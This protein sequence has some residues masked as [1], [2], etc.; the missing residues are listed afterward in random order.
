V[1][2]H[3]GPIHLL[4][5][6]VQF[7]LLIHLVQFHLVHFLPKKTPQLPTAQPLRYRRF[8][9]STAEYLK[10]KGVGTELASSHP[11]TEKSR[12]QHM[13]HRTV[14]TRRMRIRRP[15]VGSECKSARS[16]CRRHGRLVAS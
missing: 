15:R 4:I 1:Q 8:L 14:E 6:L 7:H 10:S 11:S 3:L 2:F 13:S 16:K 12:H 5:H 9:C